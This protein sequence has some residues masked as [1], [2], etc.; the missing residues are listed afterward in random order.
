[1]F[2]TLELCYYLLCAYSNNQ[3]GP[4]NNTFSEIPLNQ[5]GFSGDVYINEQI[6]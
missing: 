6:K 3:S 1:M 2:E 5:M 4:I